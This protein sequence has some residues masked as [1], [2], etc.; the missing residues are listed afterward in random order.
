[1][2]SWNKRQ[3]MQRIKQLMTNATWGTIQAWIGELSFRFACWYL[4]NGR[5]DCCLTGKKKLKLRWSLM[6]KS[7]RW[8][9]FFMFLFW[10]K[11]LVSDSRITSIRTKLSQFCLGSNH[12]SSLNFGVIGILWNGHNNGTSSFFIVSS[13]S[14]RTY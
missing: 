8:S 1:M 3:G 12:S 13:S 10:S 11:L 2:I 6:M 14:S 5:N 7:T 9:I 4:W